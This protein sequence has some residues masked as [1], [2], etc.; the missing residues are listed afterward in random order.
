MFNFDKYQIASVLSLQINDKVIVDNLNRDG[1]LVVKKIS[2]HTDNEPYTTI[3]FETEFGDIVSDDYYTE[4]FK[5]LKL[6]DH[7]LDVMFRFTKRVEDN[8]VVFY[9]GELYPAFELKSRRYKPFKV[10]VVD[11]F[12]I[13]PDNLAFQ[14]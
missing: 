7:N 5:V 13:A 10:W 14:L 8:A 3:S 12:P 9:G 6:L 4:E 1:L 11:H 2:I